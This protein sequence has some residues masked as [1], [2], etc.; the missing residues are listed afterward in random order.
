MMR[1]AASGLLL[2]AVAAG[3]ETRDAGPGLPGAG[4][5]GDR[6]GDTL[7]PVQVQVEVVD[8]VG[9]ER[10]LARHRGQVVLVD[11]WATWCGPCLELFPHTVQLARDHGPSGLAVISVS[12]DDPETASDVRAY[13]QQ[14]G[15]GFDNLISAHGA[16]ERSVTD[17]EISGGTVPH[18]KLYD[19]AGR[20]RY[21][22][23]GEPDAPLTPEWIEMHVRQLLNE[24]R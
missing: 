10:V 15:A 9:Y 20:L 6:T 5:A 14:Q 23:G 4:S 7:G 12:L 21:D 19:R 2:L 13:L 11:F 22:L 24:D 16:G 18:F 17:F 1:I 8:R 3:C